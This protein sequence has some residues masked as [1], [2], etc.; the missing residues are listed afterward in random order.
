MVPKKKRKNKHMHEVYA[1]R[2]FRNKLNKRRNANKVATK[3][4]RINRQ[5]KK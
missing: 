1:E 5:R 2:E 4:K 3:K